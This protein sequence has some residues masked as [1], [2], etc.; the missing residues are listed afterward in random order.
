M[1]VFRFGAE[2]VKI[3]CFDDEA[4]AVSTAVTCC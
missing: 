1:R 4:A 2:L 3:N